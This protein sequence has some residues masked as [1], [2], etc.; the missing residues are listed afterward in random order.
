MNNSPWKNTPIANSQYLS[1]LRIRPVP[2]SNNDELY[3]IEAMYHQRPDLLAYDL[4]GDSSLWWVFTQRNMDILKDPIYDFVQ[5]K[6][7]YLPSPKHINEAL[8]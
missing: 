6:E 3:M 2:A 5:G 7:I 1:I 8:S 4:Y